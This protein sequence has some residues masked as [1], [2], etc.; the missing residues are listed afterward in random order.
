MEMKTHMNEAEY[1]AWCKLSVKERFERMVDGLFVGLAIPCDKSTADGGTIRSEKVLKF[2]RKHL[3]RKYHG[4]A[5][6]RVV[7]HVDRMRFPVGKPGSPERVAA[8]ADQYASLAE[9]ETSP[10]EGE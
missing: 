6:N 4:K 7:G 10:F 9:N 5:D 1:R 3:K 2:S 8:L